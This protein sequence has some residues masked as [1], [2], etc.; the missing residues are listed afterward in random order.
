MD[1]ITEVKA[2]TPYVLGENV[3]S[4]FLAGTI[5]N[6]EGEKWHKK[7]I[8]GFTVNTSLIMRPVVFFNPRRDN[9]NASLKQTKE[10]P[11]FLNQVT[12]ELDN[13]DRSDIIFFYILKDSKSPITLMELG[14]VSQLSK[15]T[16]VVCED[17]FWRRGN[18]EVLC[19]RNG[20]PLYSNLDAGIMKL[21]L[22]YPKV[23]W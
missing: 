20:I 18:V 19:E 22:E 13:I 5:D 12:W 17:G 14:M 4:I 9:W 1:M 7:V 8:D 2:P 16:I 3:V 15:N 23:L 11:A 6:G 21:C 10:E